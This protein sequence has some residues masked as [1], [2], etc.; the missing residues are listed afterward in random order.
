MATLDAILFRFTNAGDTI[1]TIA[2]TEKLNLILE[3]FLTL[4]AN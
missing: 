2:N 1:G 3:Q 4:Q